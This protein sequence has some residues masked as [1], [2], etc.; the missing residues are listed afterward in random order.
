MQRQLNQS[1]RGV[2]AA[3]VALLLIPIMGF[4]AL[5]V[6]YGYLLKVRTDL[7]TAADAAALAAVRE[8]IPANHG[9]QNVAQAR[10]MA[11]SFVEANMGGSFQ[12]RDSDIQIGRYDP[13]TIY[14]NVQLLNNGTLDT[15]RITI[16]RD[17][18]SNSPV[19]LFF[20]R[21]IGIPNCN[22]AA[23]ATAVL[24]RSSSLKVGGRA[25][26]FAVSKSVWDAH[27]VGDQFQTYNGR[28]VDSSGQSISGNWGTVNLG[29]QNNSTSDLS[30]QIQNGLRQ[31]DLNA[32]KANG[33]IGDSTQIDTTQPMSVQ[34]DPGLSSGMKSA[35]AA[36]HGQTRY[37]P[38]FDT[39]SGSGNNTNYR[40]IGWGAVRVINSNFQG[41]NNTYITF[42][43]AIT[44]DAK[45]TPSNNLSDVTNTI[46][47]AYA[48]AALVE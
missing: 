2:V 38:I 35:V 27:R 14:S 4:L 15:V 28:V 1:R 31:K 36:I 12:V 41:S 13:T 18:N 10:S 42:E 25:L 8:L 30:A 46:D 29:A 23:T 6:D 32:L 47:G 5:A 26:A 37:I 24:Q 16:R 20:A 40:I 7:Q 9:A 39:V 11:R 34:G 3:K 43:R 19:G 48:V 45:L 44:Y 17:Q 33:R 21:A 22:V